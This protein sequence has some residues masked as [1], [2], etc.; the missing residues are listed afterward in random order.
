MNDAVSFAQINSIL[1]ILDDQPLDASRSDGGDAAS[2]VE[3][4]DCELAATIEI[5]KRIMALV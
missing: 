1:E 2:A 3:A 5:N 4:D